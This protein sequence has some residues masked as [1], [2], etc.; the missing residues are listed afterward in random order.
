M[1]VIGPGRGR[2]V[3]T[4]GGELAVL[5]AGA[6]V[7]EIS[8]LTGQPRSA[9]VEAQEK[10]EVVELTAESLREVAL[11]NPEVVKQISVVAAERQAGIERQKA[12]AAAG[13]TTVPERQL[14]LLARI[15]VFLRLPNF[16]GD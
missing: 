6:Y 10:C 11:V 14:P 7:G 5:E 13:L 4:S 12:V 2:A 3:E 9:T 1:F 16:L 8:M 15:Q